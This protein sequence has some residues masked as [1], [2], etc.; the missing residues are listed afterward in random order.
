MK[1]SLTLAGLLLFPNLALCGAVSGP[2]QEQPQPPDGT[3]A[4]GD[5]SQGADSQQRGPRGDRQGRGRPVFGKISALGSDSIEV[6]GPEGNKV[7]LKLTSGT[8]F[9]KDRQPAK[10]TDFKVGD[11]VVVRTDQADGKGTTALLVATGQ[12]GM[13]GQGEPGGP[14]RSFA[15]G[16]SGTLGKDF[17]IGEVKAVDPPRL[18]VLRTDH[19]SQTLQLNE[20][21]SLR[22]GRESITMADIQ[23]GDHVIARG[24]VEGNV[25][26]PKNLN[27][28]SSE[29]WER[30]QERMA[31]GGPGTSSAPGAP[32]SP[33][34]PAANSTSNPPNPPEPQN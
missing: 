8:E 5:G 30:M 31:G 18:T 25:F 2:G 15:G 17:V 7:T 9:R 14:G 12:F 20:E 6:T 26:V 34:S 19:V 3:W 27:V 33:N 22:R 13:R 4:R 29:Q 21:T 11:P 10:L 23:A 32:A 16:M 24:A 28:V 1:A